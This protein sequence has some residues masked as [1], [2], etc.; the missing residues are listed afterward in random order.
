VIQRNTLLKFEPEDDRNEGRKGPFN[1]SEFFNSASSTEA[2][3]AT[4]QALTKL[5]LKR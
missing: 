2:R 3:A 1:S 4:R 5:G